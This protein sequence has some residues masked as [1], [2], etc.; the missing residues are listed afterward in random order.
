M[1]LKYFLLQIPGDKAGTRT[2]VTRAKA[3]TIM[4]KLD[5]LHEC[6]VKKCIFFKDIFLSCKVG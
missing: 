1:A 4:W 2:R 6:L 3:L 5:V